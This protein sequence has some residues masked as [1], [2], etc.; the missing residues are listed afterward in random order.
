MSVAAANYL[1]GKIVRLRFAIVTKSMRELAAGHRFRVSSAAAGKLILVE[2]QP[3]KGC[4]LYLS[5]VPVS[6][7]EIEASQPVEAS[8]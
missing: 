3:S 6:E 1:V 5:K 7:V 8:A 4:I 2:C